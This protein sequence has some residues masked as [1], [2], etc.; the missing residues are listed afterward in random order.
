MNIYKD[1]NSIPTFEK[2]VITIGSFD[3]LHLGHRK[4]LKRVTALATEIGGTSVMITF[5]PH[6]RR[7][8]DPSTGNLQFLNTID[9]KISILRNLGI[10]NLIIIPF[11]FEFSRMAPREYIENF[12]YKVFA[13]A[14]IVIGYDHRFGLNRGGDIGLLKEYSSQYNFKVIEIPKQEIEEIAVS[15]TVIR[16]SLLSGEIDNASLF[17]G[18]PYLISGIVVHGDKFGAKLGYPTANIQVAEQDKLIAKSGIYAVEVEVDQSRFEGMLYIGPRPTIKEGLPSVIEVHIFDF[19]QNIYERPITVY[20]HSYIR[21]DK[22]LNSLEQL[23]AQMRLD[24]ISVKAYF[25]TKASEIKKT[26]SR[27]TIAIL[28]YNGEEMLDSYLP[29]VEYSC[30]EADLDIVVIDNGSSDDSVEYLEEWHPEIKIVSLVEN[31]GFAEGYNRGLKDVSTEYVVLLN[32]DVLVTEGWLEPI[33]AMLDADP[34]I[35]IVQPTILSLENKALYEYA[36]A[37]GGFIDNLGYPYC[38]GRIFDHVEPEKDAYRNDMEIFWA[39][40]AA[41]VIRT[42]LFKDLGGF[43]KS[44]FAHQEEIDLCWRAKKAGHKVYCCGSSKVYHL[45]GGTLDYG[46]SKKIYYN[47]RNNLFMLTKNES[48][49]KLLWLLPVKLV[50]DGIAGLKFLLAG[51]ISSMIAIVKAHISYY[52]ALPN[53]VETNN[54]ENALIEKCRIA[55]DRSATGRYHSS[56]VWDY[57]VKGRKTFDSIK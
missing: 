5:H 48:F 2:S 37:A 55:E 13:P 26:A 47:F 6:P 57:F 54:K 25:A 44:F 33:I 1:L 39:S 32:S 40:G 19:N 36:G 53:I 16:K 27:A 14:Y 45:G 35:G 21:D 10:D 38:R 18:S 51:N 15:S 11:S 4:I 17:L 9:E 24:E 12:L 23:S 3:G 56:I 30:D 46:S 50:L 20:L 8:V 43:D 7:V 31:Y 34:A 29:M 41:L 22:K 28:N 42:K 52:A 49:T